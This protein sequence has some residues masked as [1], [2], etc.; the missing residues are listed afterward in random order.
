MIASKLS[1]IEILALYQYIA[2]NGRTW[3]ATLR[4]DWMR[5]RL[6]GPIHQLRNVSY[7]GPSGLT[8]IK[9]SDIMARWIMMNKNTMGGTQ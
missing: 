7:F 2:E 8:Q 9:T 6:T 5:A 3:K 4:D 1:A